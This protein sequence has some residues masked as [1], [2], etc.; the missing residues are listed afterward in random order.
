LKKRGSRREKSK[1]RQDRH[2]KNKRLHIKRSREGR[3]EQALSG[4]R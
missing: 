1:E 2:R 3:L 4:M